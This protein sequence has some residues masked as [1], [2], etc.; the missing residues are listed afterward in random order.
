[1]VEIN[2]MLGLLLNK[3]NKMEY[4]N[5]ER[6]GIA[7]ITWLLEDFFSLKSVLWLQVSSCRVTKHRDFCQT[8]WTTRTLLRYWGF[9]VVFLV[10][11]SFFSQ[12]WFGVK[13]S[14]Q[15]SCFAWLWSIIWITDWSCC[16]VFLLASYMLECETLTRIIFALQVLLLGVIVNCITVGGSLE[17]L[18]PIP[19]LSLKFSHASTKWRILNIHETCAAMD[20]HCIVFRP[21]LVYIFIQIYKCYTEDFWVSF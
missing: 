20:T 2:V 6:G 21:R 4:V 8:S 3:F 7:L 15:K 19:D 18:G 11:V 9:F 10:C 5:G 17:A 13:I 12:F 1:M 14:S 16:L